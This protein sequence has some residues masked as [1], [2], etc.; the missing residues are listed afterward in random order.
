MPCLSV[1]QPDATGPRR[2]GAPATEMRDHGRMAEI[3][4]PGDHR[5][6][7]D[8]EVDFSNGGGIQGQDFRLDIE[9]D[10]ITDEALAAYIVADL[11]LLMVGEVRI[12]SKRIIAERHKRA[13]N[14]GRDATSGRLIDLSHSVVDGMIT[15]PGLPGPLITEHLTREDSRSHYTEGTTFSIGSIQMVGN[16]G[17]YLD[18]PFHRYPDG[19]DLAGL[20]LERVA[21]LEGVVVRPDLSA[22]RAIGPEA[23]A[24]HPLA[25]RAV[26]VQTGWDR[27][28]RTDAYGHGHPFLSSSAASLLVEAGAA[29]VGI[30]S[31]NIDDTADGRRPAHSGLLAAGIPIV[32]HLTGLAGLPATGFRFFAVPVKVE[33]FG[34][35]P[36]RCFAILD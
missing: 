2:D 30:D 8:F 21:A 35:F 10:A 28:W 34:T 23:F 17:T 9:G 5:V 11:R 18:S 16:T 26:L 3:E 33:R 12:V 7:F 32:E 27:H 36:V 25:G 20:P 13:G 1:S 6:V 22:G 31:L 14:A 19:A 15:Y 29:L 24:D 4:P